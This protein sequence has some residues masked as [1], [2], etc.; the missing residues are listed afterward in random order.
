MVK[1]NQLKVPPYL[2]TAGATVMLIKYVEGSSLIVIAP[3]NVDENVIAEGINQ[4]VVKTLR[5]NPGNEKAFVG[6]EGLAKSPTKNEMAL[7]MRKAKEANITEPLIVYRIEGETVYASAGNDQIYYYNS[8]TGPTLLEGDYTI[9]EKTVGRTAYGRSAMVTNEYVKSEN[10][11]GG[12]GIIGMTA[13]AGV[14]AL[15]YSE[16]RPRSSDRPEG[17]N[18]AFLND[19]DED[20]KSKPVKTVVNKPKKTKFDAYRVKTSPSFGVGLT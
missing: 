14:I 12:F 2:R 5:I 8:S 17:N 11:N 20:N 9:S 7:I 16:S 19:K 4:G 6:V 18:S 15:A 10:D 3:N 1:I 13:L